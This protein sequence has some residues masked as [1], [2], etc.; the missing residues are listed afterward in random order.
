M[1]ALKKQISPPP[2]KKNW[3]EK[4]IKRSPFVK[5]GRG[6]L[7]TSAKLQGHN[8]QNRRGHWHLKEFWGFMLDPACTRYTI[9]QY[10]TYVYRHEK[11]VAEKES[12]GVPPSTPVVGI[13][14][15][16]RWQQKFRCRLCPAVQHCYCCRTTLA[17][18][19]WLDNLDNRILEPRSAV[20]GSAS[21]WWKRSSFIYRLV[22]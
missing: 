1:G 16:Y 22:V 17:A 14:Y 10:R 7:N 20:V 5:V 9:Q 3:R 8:S 15:S 18:L 4:K 19:E 13:A 11:T 21:A 12:N 2:K 6:T